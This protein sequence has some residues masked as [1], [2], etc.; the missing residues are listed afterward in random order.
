MAAANHP[1]IQM[2]HQALLYKIIY[3]QK[4]PLI[5]GFTLRNELSHT[6]HAEK[7]LSDTIGINTSNTLSSNVKRDE[8]IKLCRVPNTFSIVFS[9]RFFVCNIVERDEI[10]HHICGKRI[11]NC[12]V[13]KRCVYHT[14]TYSF[15]ITSCG[16]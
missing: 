10:F 13:K 5:L 12:V 7:R 2:N 9:E 3:F 6:R 16:G 1:S 4:A 11:I 15:A 8:T 14:S